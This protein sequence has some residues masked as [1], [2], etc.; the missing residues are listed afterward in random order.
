[1]KFV[2]F[3]CSALLLLA[4]S[5]L[6]NTVVQEEAMSWAG[7][8]EEEGEA[9]I[10]SSSGLRKL[11]FGCDLLKDL[12]HNCVNFNPGCVDCL[13]DNSPDDE[14]LGCGEFADDVC[15]FLKDDICP[16]LCAL[17]PQAGR[18]LQMYLC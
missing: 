11:L 17:P 16:E 8:K 6:S 14:D 10:K 1:M 3:L 13:D 2:F 7:P 9:A 18:L 12:A 15:T 5:S 4:A